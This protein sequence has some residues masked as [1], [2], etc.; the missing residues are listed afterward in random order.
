MSEARYDIIQH[1]YEEEP[2]WI[3]KD[4]VSK[5]EVELIPGVGSHVVRF[6]LD[7]HPLVLTPPDLA[8][9]REKSSRFGVPIL[10]PPNRIHGAQF[11]Y[12]DRTYQYP[13]KAGTPHYMHGELSHKPWFVA[14][15]GADE[16]RGA[17]L[18][19][20]FRYQDHLDLFEHFPHNL[21][22]EMTFRLFEGKLI[23]SGTIHNE[24]MDEAPLAL[25]FHPYFPVAPKL[26]TKVV[27][28]AITEWPISEDGFVAG[29]PEATDACE[30]LRS[31]WS[32]EDV[33]SEGYMLLEMPREQSNC[34]ELQDHE[35]GTKIVVES[36]EQFPF[37]VLFKPAW[38][39]AISLEP[40]TY[41]TDGF[42]SSLDVETTGVRGLDPGD[43]FTYEW[44]VWQAGLDI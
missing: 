35:R 23:C 12:K 20:R 34:C 43:V 19:T 14:E 4:N 33:P 31:G 38:A 32:F 15:S 17:Y 36:S 44:S 7:G 11:T 39:D 10:F 30:Q 28:P 3:L 16:E 37:M 18:V 8:A 26:S 13:P 24:G 2:S 21:V 42:N 6:E 9:L 5:A 25:G 41:V 1:H 29:L 40:Y 27:I 22:F